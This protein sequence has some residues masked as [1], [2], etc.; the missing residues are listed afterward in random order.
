MHYNWRHFYCLYSYR[1]LSYELISAWEFGQTE[2]WEGREGREEGQSAHM[3]HTNFALCP[4]L[5]G[6]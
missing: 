6:I 3:N 2:L 5:H 1:Q 4:T